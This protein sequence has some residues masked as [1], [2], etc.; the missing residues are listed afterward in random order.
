MGERAAEVE[1]LER[2]Q[3]GAELSMERKP[4]YSVG[5]TQAQRGAGEQVGLDP[6]L[7]QGERVAALGRPGGQK[8]A[9]EGFGGVDGEPAQDEI[10]GALGAELERQ[11]ERGRR[12]QA[13]A[14]AEARAGVG[15]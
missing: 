1:P 13:T 12:G 11:D 3:L 9:A 15:E 2:G 10:T 4:R 5:A 8:A 6:R 14:Q 7:A